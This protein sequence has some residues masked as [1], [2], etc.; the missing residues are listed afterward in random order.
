[1]RTCEGPGSL[2]PGPALG[3]AHARADRLECAP[4]PARQQPPRSRMIHRGQNPGIR[5]TRWSTSMVAPSAP[6]DARSKTPPGPEGSNGID[7]RGR[8]GQPAG[9]PPFQAFESKAPASPPRW[10]VA[11]AR[12]I[13]RTGQHRGA[14]IDRRGRRGQ[15]AGPPPFWAFE[16]HRAPAPWRGGAVATA[17]LVP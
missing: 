2:H 5:T 9:P 10:A 17:S 11:T 1:M 7:R 3:M 13:P 6:R 8:R 15:P 14:R 16:K 12:T 4:A